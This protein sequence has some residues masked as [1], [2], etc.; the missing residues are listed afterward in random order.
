MELV[1]SLLPRVQRGGVPQGPMKIIVGLGNPG[2]EHAR[3][4]HNIGF[5]VV[6]HFARQHGLDFDKVQKRARLATGRVTVPGAGSQ[7]LV[8]AKP[9]TYMNASGESIGPLMSFYKLTP[10]D[11][12]VVYDDLDLPFGRIRLRPGGGAGGHKGIQ[13][14]IRHLGSEDFARLRVGIGRPP[15]RMDPAAYVLQDFSRDQETEMAL[16]RVT[17][18]EAIDT[19]LAQ[20]IE[21]AMNQ[22]NGV[23]GTA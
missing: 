21:A 20:G 1:R 16:V 10:A 19:W 5:Q 6:E 18:V 15:G 8:L 17:C 12:L 7:R 11:L 2:P 22:Y 14:L 3:N 23:G 4:R 9:L 13:S